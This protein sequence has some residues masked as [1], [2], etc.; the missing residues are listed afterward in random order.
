M[1]WGS[2]SKP[3]HVD[4][5][6]VP[7]TLNILTSSSSYFWP[8][9]RGRKL[10]ISAKIQPTDHI[11][12]ELEYFCEPSNTSGGRYH[13]VTTS[14]VYPLTG[15]PEALASP[16]SAIL[17]MLSLEMRR[18]WGLRSLWSTFFSWQWLMP[19]RSW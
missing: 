3:G 9:K 11:S 16:K 12:I 8:G 6:G 5:H 17:R 10:T 7:N 18:F 19:W 4:S 14:W 15:I 13:K 1:K 2:Y